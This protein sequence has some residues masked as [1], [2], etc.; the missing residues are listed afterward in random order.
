MKKAWVVSA[1]LAAAMLMGA[2]HASAATGQVAHNDR[3]GHQGDGDWD[4]DDRYRDDDRRGGDWDRDDRG[5]GYRNSGRGFAGTWRAVDGSR[6]DHRRD[7]DLMSYFRRGNAGMLP[8]VFRIEPAGRGEVRVETVNGALL[9]E[10]DRQGQGTFHTYA[11][12][13]NGRQI[14]ET[15]T[16]ERNGRR[17]VVHTTMSGRGGNRTF[18]TVYARA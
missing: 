11:R 12:A 2:I 18:T 3:G 6:D 16:L 4:R 15:F 17:L 14:R 10:G 13:S 5:R 8:D 7:R 1:T 9:R